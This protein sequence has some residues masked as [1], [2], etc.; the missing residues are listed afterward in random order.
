MDKESTYFQCAVGK[1][2]ANKNY[3]YQIEVIFAIKCKELQFLKFLSMTM[4]INLATD[5]A[6]KVIFSEK[7][8]YDYRVHV[9]FQYSESVVKKT[10]CCIPL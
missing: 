1:W 2:S 4:L 9:E 3:K 7:S 6:S 5:T 8:L 10:T